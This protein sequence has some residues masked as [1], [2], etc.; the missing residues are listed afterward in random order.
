MGRKISKGDHF[1]SADKMTYLRYIQQT[2]N[3]FITFMERQP[4]VFDV[5][6]TLY[7]CFV[8]AVYV[9]ILYVF[10]ECMNSK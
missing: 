10:C 4:Y 2:K 8:F 6:P 3:I 5:G 7:K 1:Y 9:H